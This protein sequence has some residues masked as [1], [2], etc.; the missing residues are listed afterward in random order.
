MSTIQTQTYRPVRRTVSMT[1]LE[2]GGCGGVA[3][4]ASGFG[5][6]PICQTEPVRVFFS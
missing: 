1:H 3:A 5:D 4:C 2:S 6:I